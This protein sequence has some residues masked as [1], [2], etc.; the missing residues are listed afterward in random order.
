MTE[1][2]KPAKPTKVKRVTENADFI[3]MIQRQIRALE[4]R[5]ISDPSILAEVIMLAQRLAEIPNVVIATSAARYLAEGPMAAPSAGEIANL[6]GMKKQSAS[7]RR[8]IGDRILFD[9]AMGEDTIPQRERIARTLARKHAEATMAD[10]LG[11][12]DA[13][14]E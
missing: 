10:W 8:K 13:H 14:A 11:R 12:K 7:E 9:R 1:Q 2:V 4:A 6:L 5:A 3:A